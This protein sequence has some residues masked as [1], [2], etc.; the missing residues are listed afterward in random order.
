MI[1]KFIFKNIFLFKD[2]IINIQF[3]SFIILNQYGP[4]KINSKCTYHLH[5]V[6]HPKK[7]K[8]IDSTNKFLWVSH[9]EPKFQHDLLRCGICRTQGWHMCTVRLEVARTPRDCDLSYCI[10]IFVE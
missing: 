5:E 3:V 4:C 1:F 9:S 2:M 10:A 6:V 7:K 8:V